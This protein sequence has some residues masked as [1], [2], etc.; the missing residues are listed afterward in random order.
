MNGE[1]V[2]EAAF[3]GQSAE[4]LV[5]RGWLEKS[6]RGFAL[7]AERS[8]VANAWRRVLQ[9]ESSDLGE[10]D[11]TLDG[12]MAELVAEITGAPSRRDEL[13]RQLRG[14]GVAAFGL[15]AA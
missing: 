2:E 12:W 10:C 9:G 3:G 1:A 7:S 13:R 6:G 8:A 11:G 4:I 5:E 15:L 14:H